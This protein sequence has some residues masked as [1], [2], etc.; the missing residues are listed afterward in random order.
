MFKNICTRHIICLD[1]PSSVA[2]CCTTEDS[3]SRQIMH[4]VPVFAL[5]TNNHTD[6]ECL[7]KFVQTDN[8]SSSIKTA[9]AVWPFGCWNSNHF[10]SC[11]WRMRHVSIIDNNYYHYYDKEISN[12]K[13]SSQSETDR[14]RN[15]CKPAGTIWESFWEPLCRQTMLTV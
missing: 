1:E 7:P 3:S 9:I 10:L 15:P 6:S 8:V 12:H 14:L 4:L 5:E 13:E 2:Y 11:K